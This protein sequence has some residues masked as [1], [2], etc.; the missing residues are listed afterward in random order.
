MLRGGELSP[1]AAEARI[2]VCMMKAHEKSGPSTSV[3]EEVIPVRSGDQRKSS[4]PGDFSL[5]RRR[6][7]T[8]P[9]CS[10]RL[11]TDFTLC[12]QYFI[13]VVP[14]LGCSQRGGEHTSVWKVYVG[15]D[16][17]SLPFFAVHRSWRGW[18]HDEVGNKR[19]KLLVTHIKNLFPTSRRGWEQVGNNSPN[20]QQRRGMG[21]NA[22][23]K[24][25]RSRQPPAVFGDQRGRT[26]FRLSIPWLPLRRSA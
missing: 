1:A 22:T 12:Y 23:A 11:G 15:S 9:A 5:L 19:P 16:P 8:D 2:R 20:G 17:Q 3:G 4:D 24:I 21:R 6:L 14:N 13:L 26:A 18:E 10:S 7:G 25:S